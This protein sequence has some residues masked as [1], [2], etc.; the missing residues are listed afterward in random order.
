MAEQAATKSPGAGCTPITAKALPTAARGRNGIC[1]MGE[2]PFVRSTNE[3]YS[4][5]MRWPHWK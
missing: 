3:F 1:P 5:G 4:K 2:V